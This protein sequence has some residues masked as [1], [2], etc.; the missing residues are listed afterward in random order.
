LNFLNKEKRTEAKHGTR[1]K[2]QFKTKKEP[3]ANSA[4]PVLS[5]AS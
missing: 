5:L 3:A 4:R 2:E 1:I